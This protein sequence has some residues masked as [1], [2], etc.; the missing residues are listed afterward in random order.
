[1]SFYDVFCPAVL[2]M[3]MRIECEPGR[4]I[5][6]QQMAAACATTPF[7]NEFSVA[8]NKLQFLTHSFLLCKKLL[9]GFCSGL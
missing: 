2:A 3:H 5:H 6:S 7:D 4:H 8:H 1:M 9:F